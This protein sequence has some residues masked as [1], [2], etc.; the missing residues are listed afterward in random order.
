MSKTALSFLK[1]GYQVIPLSRKTGTPII[2]FKDIPIT[3]DV[4]NSVDWS[5]CD[6]ALLMRGIWCIDIDTHQMDENLAQEMFRMIKIFGSDIISV[7]VT[8]KN[9][10]GLD[11]YSSIINHEYKDELLSNFRNTYIELTQTGGMHILFRKQEGIEYAQKIGVMNGVDIKANDNNYVKI[12]PSVGREVLRAVKELA[13]YEGKFEK[14]IF[15]PRQTIVTQYFTDYLPKVKGTHAG[16]EA[17][18][19]V[20]TG[21]SVNR[22]DDLFK[23]ACWAFENNQDISDLYSI[24]G[25]IKGSD[26][27]T[28]EEFERTIESARRKA[29]YVSW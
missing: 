16:H 22:N 14:E 5:D 13:I 20:S 23:A 25:T 19:R 18:E 17:F 4:I 29:N 9:N 1:K 28:P 6:Y 3:E 21:N 11:G 7:M 26:V 27:F 8:D 12:F 10:F 2:Q 24:V 15:T